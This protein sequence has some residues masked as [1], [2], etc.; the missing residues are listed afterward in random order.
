MARIFY[1]ICDLSNDGI[2]GVRAVP[3]NTAESFVTITFAGLDPTKRYVFRGAGVRNGGYGTR[4][5]MATISAAEFT[6]AHINGAGG[7]AF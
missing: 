6:D 7:P 5:S 4:W 3:P 2:V 1:G